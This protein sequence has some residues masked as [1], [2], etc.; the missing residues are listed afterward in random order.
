MRLAS[1]PAGSFGTASAPIDVDHMLEQTSTNASREMMAAW[2]DKAAGDLLAAISSDALRADREN[3]P[4][5][6]EVLFE[7]AKCGLLGGSLPREVGGGGMSLLSWGHALE[8]V[9]YLCD[10]AGFALITSLFQA[11]A[12]MIFA[13]GHPFLIDKYVRPCSSGARLCAFA[14]TEDSDAFSIKTRMFRDGADYVINGSKILVTGG[15]IAD[16]FMLYAVNDETDDLAVVVVDRDDPGVCVIPVETMGLRSAGLAALTFERVRISKEQVIAPFNGIDHVQAFLSPRRAILCGAPIGRMQ[17]IIDDCIKILSRTVRYGD[18]LTNMQLLQSRLGQMQMKVHASQTLLDRALESLT[19]GPSNG[20]FSEI[21]S[22]AKHEVTEHSISVALDAIR[23]TGARGY[24]CSENLER[25]VR[26][27]LGAVSG[28][29]AQDVLQVNLGAFAI[30][31][32][33]GT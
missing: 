9:G 5:R 11:V 8:R 31:R 20:P 16:S 24:M 17:R 12:N 22:T 10:D 26:D 32:A 13:S 27:F 30:A 3:T 28:A 7:A 25:Y 1:E 14:Y 18:P 4:I 19:R 29:G 23:L 6:R 15:S 2:V 21:I 33:H